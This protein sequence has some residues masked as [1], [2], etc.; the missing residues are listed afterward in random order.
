MLDW[1]ACLLVRSL[2][3]LLCRLPPSVCVFLGAG[4]GQ[5]AYWVQP[6][7]ARIGYLN[8][9]AAFGDRLS[10]AQTRRI[11]RQ[12]FRELGSGLVEML[13]LPSI[14]AAYVDRYIEILGREH[15][16]Q[17]L[18]TGRPLVLLSGHFGN[19]ELCPIVTA[20]RGYPITAL[21]RAQERLP[22]LYQ[23]L[24]SLRESKGCRI[25]HK[26]GALKQLLQAL[27][28]RELVG[29]VADQA[30]RKGLFIEFFGRQALFTTG[31]FEL[32]RTS[33]AM[34]VPGFIHRVRGPFHRL[35]VEPPI[36]LPRSGRTEE[37]IRTG[38]EQF[39][40]TLARHIEQDPGQWL[41]L[42]RRWKHAPDRRVLILNDGKLGHLKQS[43]T[44]LKALKAQRAHV[45]EE[46][47]EVRYRHR[48]GRFVTLVW[49]WLI[50]RGLGG[51]SCLRLSLEPASW[52]RLASCYADVIV[53]C[54]ASVAPVNILMSA[55][56]RA[57]PVVIMDPAPLPLRKFSLAF[58]PLHDGP[59]KR[60][61]VIQTLGSLSV[62]TD[63]QIVAARERLRAHPR[64]RPS[65]ATGEHR[66]GIAVFLGGDTP[67]YQVT[68]SFAE[69]LFRQI[70]A[71]CEDTDGFCLA[72]TS[73]RT[74]QDVERLLA[75][76]LTKHPRCGL[77]LL[78]SRDQ[79]DGTIEGMLGWAQVVVVTGESISMVT[80]A[81]ASGRY[82][83]VVE[84]P[85]RRASLG[86]VTKPR[87]FIRALGDQ[88]YIRSHPLPEVG[89]AIRR[90][91]LDRPPV[92]RLDTYAAV[93]A[94][95]KRL[96]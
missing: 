22:K 82:V 53:S 73:R 88:G 2:G 30:S 63:Q 33:G 45:R 81:C 48:L 8:L 29:I 37:V 28:R 74:P 64:F 90:C 59:P 11:V 66:P 93:E 34:L 87:R 65:I 52:K 18:A 69:A 16:E 36:D 41:W 46:I 67:E 92:R 94:A 43:L 3:W 83:V 23:L 42:H 80:E 60:P 21:A 1:L 27:D 19:W 25:V 54:G 89:H 5:L 4:A 14:N 78:A 91:L 84:P 50:P 39:A 75:D 55:D 61:N 86:H 31:P 70:L 85:L 57:K 76:Q 10:P 17:A 68:A 72:T 51:L 38:I 56:N 49:A 40:K 58:V 7:R 95:V 9:K 44:V 79:L 71:I 6:K 12:V 35:V 32:A 15:F 13:R 62:I 47:V 20:L 96:F 26:G 77:L 24:V